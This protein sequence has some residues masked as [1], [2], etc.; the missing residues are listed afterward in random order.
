MHETAGVWTQIGIVSF[1]NKCAQPG[2]PG[3]YTRVTYFLDWI[4]KNST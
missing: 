2:F 3:V 1:G 4:D